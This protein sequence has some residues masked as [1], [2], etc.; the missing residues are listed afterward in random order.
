M[1][2]RQSCFGEIPH[3]WIPAPSLTART[4]SSRLGAGGG[5]ERRQPRFRDES[6][7][8]INFEVVYDCSLTPRF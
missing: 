2:D 5:V 6:T 4:E 3:A 1:S 7:P 8:M